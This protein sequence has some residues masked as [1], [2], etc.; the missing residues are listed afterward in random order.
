[1]EYRIW[2]DPC[3]VSFNSIDSKMEILRIVNI[4]D[5]DSN[6]TEVY[7]RLDSE[8]KQ[9]DEIVKAMINKYSNIY[10]IGIVDLNDSV[11]DMIHGFIK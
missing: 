1:M 2:I 7:I 11:D 3:H 9:N 4:L 6:V 5:G 8:N 10:Y